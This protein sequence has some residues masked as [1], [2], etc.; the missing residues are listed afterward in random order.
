[1][2]AKWISYGEYVFKTEDEC[3]RFY[4]QEYAEQW[5]QRM[6][7]GKY[8][9]FKSVEEYLKKYWEVKLEEIRL[10]RI[11]RQEEEQQLAYDKRIIEI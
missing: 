9:E 2:K 11:K 5:V 6:F 10:D 4:R 8:P 1:M 3:F 7:T